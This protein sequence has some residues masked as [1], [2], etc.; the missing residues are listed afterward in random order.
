MKIN[1][2]PQSNFPNINHDLVIDLDEDTLGGDILI[3]FQKII[4]GSFDPDSPESIDNF[5]DYPFDEFGRGFVVNWIYDW[6]YHQ[7][8]NDFSQLT[9]EYT[10]YI[11]ILCGSKEEKEAIESAITLMKEAL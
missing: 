1:V 3:D 4:A 2:E 11:K 10:F 8:V 7:Y 5:V 6:D 9:R